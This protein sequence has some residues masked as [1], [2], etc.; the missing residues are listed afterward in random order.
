MKVVK[1][2]E[3]SKLNFPGGSFDETKLIKKDNLRNT[4][5]IIVELRLQNFPESLR[6]D[7]ERI[8]KDISI[9][10]SKYEAISQILELVNN[11]KVYDEN[12][13]LRIAEIYENAKYDNV[14]LLENIKEQLFSGNLEGLANLVRNELDKLSTKLDENIKES[15]FLLVKFQ[16]VSSLVKDISNEQLEETIKLIE[17]NINKIEDSVN[18]SSK[19][20]SRFISG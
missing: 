9:N 7:V 12:L 11:S 17:A 16:N 5:E 18:I 20:V 4:D 8:Q 19:N 6:R 15:S 1:V 14:Y 2:G 13:K 10:Q 3:G